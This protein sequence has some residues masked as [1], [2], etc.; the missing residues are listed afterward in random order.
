MVGG[1]LR[2]FSAANAMPSFDATA[3]TVPACEMASIAYSTALISMDRMRTLV[4]LRKARFCT[5]PGRDAL[6]VS[7]PPL[8]PSTVLLQLLHT[9]RREDGGAAHIVSYLSIYEGQCAAGLTVVSAS[10]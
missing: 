6:L 8:C 3:S 10:L 4:A 9:F 7:D 1:M 2:T 5:Y